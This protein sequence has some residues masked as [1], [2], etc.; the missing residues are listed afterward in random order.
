LDM[1]H[2]CLRDK[3]ASQRKLIDKSIEGLFQTGTVL[4]QAARHI[5]FS[6][7]KR[8]RAALA[9]IATQAAGGDAAQA[10]PMA[11]G[12]ELLH[13]ASLIHDDIMDDA[14]SRRGRPCVH[15]VF[16]IDIAITTGDALIFEAYRELLALSSFLESSRVNE[17]LRLFSTCAVHTCQGQTDDLTFS[18]Q[19]RSIKDYLRM[20][21]RKTGSMIEAPMEGGA[22]IANASLHWRRRFR[23]FGRTLGTAF[24]IVDDA[25]DYL[26]SE[27]KVYKTI[28]NDL[29]RKKGSAMMI[30]CRERCNRAEQAVLSTAI[31]QFRLSG[32]I[33][34]VKPVLELLDKYDAIGFTQ[35]LCERYIN[36]ARQL[37][38]GIGKEPARTTLDEIANIVGY[39]GLLATARPSS[40]SDTKP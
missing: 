25:I 9:L 2:D 8:I 12:F 31:E 10:L 20:V 3:I 38:K 26:G 13:T 18:N 1:I 33:E 28:G 35:R 29:R 4:D 7:A 23:E 30:Y 14:Q 36:R 27:D 17:V 39:W 21:R 15:R 40:A 11:V 5:L 16:G 19:N 34:D 32:D 22:I 24:Q 6:K 37:I